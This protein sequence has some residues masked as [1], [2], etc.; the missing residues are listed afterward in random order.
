MNAGYAD[1]IERTMRQC[2]NQGA[3]SLSIS[4]SG[5]P[6]L[7]PLAVSS[8]LFIVADLANDGMV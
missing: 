6:T 2:Y 8:A 4:S 7:S 1:L 5:E 3:R